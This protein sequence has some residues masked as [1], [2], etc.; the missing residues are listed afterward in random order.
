VIR[1]TDF[2]RGY[3]RQLV[4]GQW[5]WEVRELVP[6]TEEDQRMAT[7]GMIGTVMVEEVQIKGRADN[8]PEA[9]TQLYE[10]IRHAQG[11][12]PASDWERLHQG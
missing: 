11:R 1:E 10:A 2:V 9:K 12:Q 6:G 7:S 4:S 8:L 3:Y 5:E